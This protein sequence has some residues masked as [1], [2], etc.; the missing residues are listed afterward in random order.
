MSVQRHS[1][2]PTLMRRCINVICPLCYFFITDDVLWLMY[3]LGQDVLVSG[4][5]YIRKD[6]S[7][8]KCINAGKNFQQTTFCNIFFL[9]FPRKK[10][11]TF[12]VNWQ[13]A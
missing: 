10:N 13:L 2:A 8:C 5:R 7:A 6:T 12:H 1:V 3:D 9:S 4:V 11:L